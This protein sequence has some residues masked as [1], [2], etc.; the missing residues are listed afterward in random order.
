MRAGEGKAVVVVGIADA[1]VIDTPDALLVTTRANAQRVKE[2]PAALSA[3]GLSS[4][5]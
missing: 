1:V 3:Q 4:L 2:A 5:I